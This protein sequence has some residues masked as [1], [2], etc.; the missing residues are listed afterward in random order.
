MFAG[1]FV[2]FESPSLRQSSL[3]AQRRAKTAAPEPKAKAG[4][5]Q[6]LPGCE[7]RLGKPVYSSAGR[8]HIASHPYQNPDDPVIH[9]GF[10][11]HGSVWLTI[12]K[13]RTSL[14]APN[15]Q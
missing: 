15:T 9:R 8:L 1:E 13:S 2:G 7:L 5:P 12:R 4:H 6:S 14:R 3:A 11:F 10:A